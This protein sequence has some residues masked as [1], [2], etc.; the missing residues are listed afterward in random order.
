M[1]RRH[2][3]LTLSTALLV[4]CGGG[5][6]EK[7]GANAS[8]SATVAASGNTDAGARGSAATADACKMISPADLAE[9]FAPRTFVVDTSG[10]VPHNRP[11]T[12]KTN[13]VTSC[14]YTSGTTMRDMMTINLTVVTAPSDA[15]HATVEQ[16]KKGVAALGLNATPV[17]IAGLG[18]AAY[19]VNLGSAQR[20]SLAVNVQRA[21]RQWLT[22][23]ESSAGDRVEESVERLTK[24]AR[25][26]LEQL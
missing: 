16:M 4:A 11:G 5:T 23:G 1:T 20:S 26:A 12:A 19:W 8:P 22:I 14:T 17:D 9:A 13:A 7:S 6:V 21:P 18:D 15:A 3:A 2:S 25:K 10:P 24:I